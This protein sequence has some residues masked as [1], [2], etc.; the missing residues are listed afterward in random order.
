MWEIYKRH[1][2]FVLGF[3]GCT[4]EVGERILAGSGSLKSSNNDYDWLGPGVYFWENSPERALQFASEAV[5][6]DPKTTRGVIREPFVIGAVIDLGLCFNLLDSGALSEMKAAYN[7]F[8]SAILASGAKA[9]KN[10]SGPARRARFLDCAVIRTMQKLREDQGVPSY[11]TMR[12]AFWEGGE[13]YP[14][15]GFSEKGHVQIAVV[16]PNK[17]LGYFRPI[18]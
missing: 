18:N 16:N 1:S 12:G 8:N 4:K 5:A 10:V 3:H 6:R 2:S 13:L 14:G 9:P 17:I 7:V 15:A 11:D